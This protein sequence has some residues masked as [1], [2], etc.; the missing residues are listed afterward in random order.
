MKKLTTI[1]QLFFAGV[2]LTGMNIFSSCDSC[3]RKE[4]TPEGSETTTTDADTTSYDDSAYDDSLSTGASTNDGTNTSTPIR[5][6]SSNGGTATTKP[7]TSSSSSNDSGTKTSGLT[8]E[9]ITNRIE[10]S[11]AKSAVD[12]NGKPIRNSGAAGSGLGTGTGSTGNNSRVT[13]KEAQKGN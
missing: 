3:S 12:K 11:D 10:N 2:V 6:K 5:S 4:A 8:E 13:T 1:K 9:E 7:A